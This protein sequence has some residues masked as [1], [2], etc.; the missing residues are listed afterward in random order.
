MNFAIPLKALGKSLA[1]MV[2]AQFGVSLDLTT[3]QVGGMRHLPQPKDLATYLNAV[4]VHP[5]GWRDMGPGGPGHT[6]HV[7]FLYDLWLIER[8][9]DDTEGDAGTDDDETAAEIIVG[10]LGEIAGMFPA[11]EWG[12]ENTDGSISIISA[13][14]KDCDCDDPLFEY[15]NTVQYRV[16]SGL[17]RVEIECYISAT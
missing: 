17:L 8:I 12:V 2:K 4:L 10:H 15:F 9:P 6:V 7:T 13:A 5:R 16:I 1:S 3:C 14:P 11:N